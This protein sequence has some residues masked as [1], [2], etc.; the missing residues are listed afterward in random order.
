MLKNLKLRLISYVI[1]YVLS[2]IDY[3]LTL[4]LWARVGVEGLGHSALNNPH[5]GQLL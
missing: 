2:K 4:A 3:L 1:M 5:F